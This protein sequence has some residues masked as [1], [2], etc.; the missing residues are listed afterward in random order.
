MASLFC[1]GIVAMFFARKFEMP[2]LFIGTNGCEFVR[3]K[4]ILNSLDNA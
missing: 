2:L 3:N 1:F 4:G